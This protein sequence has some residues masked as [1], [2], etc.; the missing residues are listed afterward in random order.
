MVAWKNNQTGG[1]NAFSLCRATLVRHLLSVIFNTQLAEMVQPK[2][3]HAHFFVFVMMV[4]PCVVSMLA[5]GVPL[6]QIAQRLGYSSLTGFSRMF[7][8][9]RG[10]TPNQYPMGTTRN[11]EQRLQI[12]DWVREKQRWIIE[13]DYDSEFQFAHRPY[14]SLQGLAAQVGEAQQIIYVGSFS[15]WAAPWL[16]GA[17][18]SV[19]RE[20]VYD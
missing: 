18:Q 5:S 3:S 12:I 2:R 19:D 17:A 8:K 16:C 10:V 7:K 11:T 4:S 6:E 15:K 1:N 9:H 13:D 14:T 20:G